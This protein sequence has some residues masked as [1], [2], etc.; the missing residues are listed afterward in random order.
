VGA[1]VTPWNECVVWTTSWPCDRVFPF[2]QRNHYWQNSHRH[3]CRF[4]MEE[5]QCTWKRDW[6]CFLTISPH[7]SLHDQCA[8]NSTFANEWTARS[9]ASNKSR[10]LDHFK[11]GYMKNIVYA[12][13]IKL[14]VTDNGCN[15]SGNHTKHALSLLFASC[16]VSW[17]VVWWLSTQQ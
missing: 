1:Y 14:S 10:S 6:E 7:F 8:L 13:K 9:L 2:M 3:S 16:C 15:C 17:F 12:V 5:W 11:W 4:F